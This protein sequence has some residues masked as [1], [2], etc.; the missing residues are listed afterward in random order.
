M[1]VVW[2]A[3]ECPWPTFGSV[4]HQRRVDSRDTAHTLIVR[5]EEKVGS[6]TVKPAAG[7][8]TMQ[9][10]RARKRSVRTFAENDRKRLQ[11]LGRGAG[12]GALERQHAFQ[13]RGCAASTT[14]RQR[15]SE[16][17]MNS[18]KPIRLR[19]WRKSLQLPQSC[20]ALQI[21]R[22]SRPQCYA[23]AVT[24][25]L[26]LLASPVLTLFLPGATWFG[27]RASPTE[28]NKIAVSEIDQATSP[29]L[30][31]AIT[32]TDVAPEPII[33]HSAVASDISPSA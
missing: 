21:L 2:S 3:D 32:V 9:R 10:R 13:S 30:R 26:F 24:A 18:C 15:E 23:L 12:A 1:N 14:H 8:S 11:R 33:A 31:S 29:P 7:F 20:L 25:L 27:D 19:S 6:R 5:L 28:P 22:G 17:V 16:E 4:P